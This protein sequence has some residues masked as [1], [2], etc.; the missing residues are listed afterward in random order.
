[1]RHLIPNAVHQY[2]AFFC[3]EVDFDKYKMF[4]VI[5]VPNLYVLPGEM[6]MVGG[7]GQRLYASLRLS[8]VTD[9]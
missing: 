5:N 6:A 3:S 9:G 1:L 8:G 4:I 2:L 7:F